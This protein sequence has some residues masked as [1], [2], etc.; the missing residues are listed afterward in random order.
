MCILNL[1]KPLMKSLLGLALGLVAVTNVHAATVV[2]VQTALG[3]YKIELYEDLAPN[4]VARFLSDVDSGRYHFTFVHFTTNTYY[5]A[6]RYVYNS[7]GQG[8]EEI[9]S[10]EPRVVEE[11]GLANTTGTIAMVRDSSNSS[12]FTGE[13]LI[14]LGTNT[15]A[16]QST[17]PVVIGTITQGFDVADAVADLW[18]VSL[19]VSP[20]VPTINYDGIFTVQCGTFNRDNL[21]QLALS[22]ESVDGDSPVNNYD[23]ATQRVNLKVDA[24]SEGLLSLAFTIEQMAPQVIIRA[25]PET[26]TA[27]AETVEGI[28]IYDSAS[29]TLTIPQL[30]IDG[31][32]TYSNMVF[33]LTDA[34]QLH[35]TLQSFTQ[36]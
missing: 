31:T 28:A 26:V 35:F 18:K 27:L 13:I 19:D 34:A 22:V 24:G 9:A 8:P 36:N 21:V 14:N 2:N 11:T 23:S 16:S 32:L 25:L 3:A 33:S 6:G 1:I 5:V 20:S 30:A 15:P 4:T 29:E 7:C 10:G 12:L 17:A